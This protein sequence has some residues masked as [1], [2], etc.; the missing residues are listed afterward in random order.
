MSATDRRAWGLATLLLSSTLY[1]DP[2]PQTQPPAAPQAPAVDPLSQ[3]LE[4]AFREAAADPRVRAAAP[5]ST[6]V[7]ALVPNITLERYRLANGL[8]V[9]LAPGGSE[10]QGAVYLTYHVGS[11]D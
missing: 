5:A 9:S 8:G 2:P 11:G 1:A 6:G 3:E 4:R 7:D 10:R